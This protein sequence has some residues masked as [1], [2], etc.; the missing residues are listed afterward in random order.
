[1]TRSSVNM[2]EIQFAEPG[3]LR[4][5]GGRGYLP[6]EDVTMGLPLPVGFL[7]LD[8]DVF[9]GI[10]NG[11]VRRSAGFLQV[12]RVSVSLPV[13]RVRPD[14]QTDRRRESQIPRAR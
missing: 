12:H 1:M 13:E 8:D 14:F 3:K 5:S 2:V 6:V 4:E 9:P 10:E 7:L 11:A